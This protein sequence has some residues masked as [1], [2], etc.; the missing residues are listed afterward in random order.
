MKKYRQTAL[1][2]IARLPWA[3]RV[4]TMED[5]RIPSKLLEAK[6]DNQQNLMA[7]WCKAGPSSLGNQKLEAKGTKQN[8]LKVKAQ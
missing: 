8:L 1:I 5:N 2:N 4:A 7:G 3:D 6:S